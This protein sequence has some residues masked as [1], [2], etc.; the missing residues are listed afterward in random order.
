MGKFPQPPLRLIVLCS[1]SLL[2]V[3]SACSTTPKNN[4]KHPTSL[5]DNP[6]NDITPVSSC[7][8][9][10]DCG[11]DI[12][13][14]DSI[15]PVPA[16]RSIDESPTNEREIFPPLIYGAPKPLVCSKETFPKE[17]LKN[18]PNLQLMW[19]HY[20]Y[21]GPQG[22]WAEVGG[23]VEINGCLPDDKGGW[24]NACTVRLSHMLN[25]AGHNIPHIKGQTVSGADG[26]QYF[27]RLDDAQ[28]YLENTFGAPDLD[29]DD[30]SGR[31]IDIPNEPGL[32][33]MKYP[34]PDFTGH[35]TV[36]NGAGTVDDV[37]VVG[38]RILYW[39][40]PCFIPA[41]RN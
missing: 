41:G 29:V 39:K 11:L 4:P 6:P 12:V 3:L 23:A 1:T 8:E 33:I 15:I 10:L 19:E 26:S 31:W 27:F 18:R 7:S 30:A 13:E 28:A 25:N 21:E 34:G 24:R 35:A 37:A 2:I 38:F 36:W 9:A 22:V 20:L 32:L 16:D 40:L 5:N 14:V 17:K